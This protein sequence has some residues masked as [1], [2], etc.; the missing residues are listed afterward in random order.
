MEMDELDTLMDHL[1]E[2]ES[3]TNKVVTGQVL[4]VL[5]AGMY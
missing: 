4:C 2:I 3:R 1:T 5:L